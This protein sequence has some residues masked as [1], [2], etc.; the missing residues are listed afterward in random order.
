M[1]LTVTIDTEEDNWGEFARDSFTVENISRIPRLHELFMR[2][3]VRP[4]YLVSYPVVTDPKSVDILGGYRNAGQCEIGTH[5]H[6]WN[7]P[8]VVDERNQ[9]NSYMCNLPAALQNRKI[10]TLTDTIAEK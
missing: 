1:Y 4:T 6:P 9:I 3:G 5:P 7:T 10:Q 8:P 2:R